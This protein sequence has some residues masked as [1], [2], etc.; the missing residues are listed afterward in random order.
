MSTTKKI[1]VEHKVE[2]DEVFAA[3]ARPKLYDLMPL[4]LVHN[5]W[6]H[7]FNSN[8]VHHFRLE[9]IHTQ[10][11]GSLLQVK[12]WEVSNASPTISTW[13]QRMRIA[14]VDRLS[15]DSYKTWVKEMQDANAMWI[16][17]VP[18]KDRTQR[19]SILRTNTTY[20]GAKVHVKKDLTVFTFTGNYLCLLRLPRGIHQQIFQ[21]LESVAMNWKQIATGHSWYIKPFQ[22]FCGS[23]RPHGDKCPYVM[24]RFVRFFP[25]LKDFYFIFRVIARDLVAHRKLAGNGKTKKGNSQKAKVPKLSAEETIEYCLAEY[26]R[27]AEERELHIWSDCE[28]TFVE[29]HRDDLSCHLRHS[30]SNTLREA[31]SDEATTE[32]RSLTRRPVKFHF[33]ISRDK[34]SRK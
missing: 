16:A 33:V 25:D 22:C 13:R 19:P 11:A 26:R 1:K 30:I 3:P 24:S 32:M 14:T 8:G 27:M 5:T 18:F 23:A 12:P 6:K 7:A 21:G 31:I 15:L 34:L 28:R 9:V 10:H 2:A 20:T 17:P 4:E 29:V